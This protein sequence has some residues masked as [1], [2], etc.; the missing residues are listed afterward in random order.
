M[1][2][3]WL[4]IGCLTGR[5]WI[6][7]GYRRFGEIHVAHGAMALIRQCVMINDKALDLECIFTN[8]IHHLESTL[9]RLSLS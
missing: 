6:S 1:K 9:R 7:S 5:E 2:G 3:R 8:I 4:D